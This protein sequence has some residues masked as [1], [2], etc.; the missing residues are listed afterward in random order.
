MGKAYPLEVPI[1]LD[2]IM[3]TMGYEDDELFGLDNAV[4]WANMFPPGGGF[5][6]LGEE[7]RRLT[8]EMFHSVSF[9]FPIPL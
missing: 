1:K 5:L 4:A 3:M 8:P 2:T 7:K 6:Y 9:S